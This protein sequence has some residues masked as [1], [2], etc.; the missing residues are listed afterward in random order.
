[1][2]ADFEQ[3]LYFMCATESVLQKVTFK[4][5]QGRSGSTGAQRHLKGNSRNFSLLSISLPLNWRHFILILWRWGKWFYTDSSC[6]LRTINV[7]H[8]QLFR[9]NPADLDREELAA[10]FP[11]STIRCGS[12]S[13]GSSGSRSRL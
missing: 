11:R 5:L 7:F 8:V 12:S 13:S 10:V 4:S 9:F 1:M 6:W 2:T 3:I